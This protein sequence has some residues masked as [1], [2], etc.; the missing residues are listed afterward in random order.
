MSGKRRSNISNIGDYQ[1]KPIRFRFNVG[2]CFLLFL[3]AYM[4]IY[5]IMS[6][7]AKHIVSYEVTKGSLS[8][9]NIYEGVAI[10]Q[11]ESYPCAGTGYLNFFAREG[12]HVAC[13]DL[14]Y[15]VDGSG[16]IGEMISSQ[17]EDALL[18]EEDLAQIQS[19]A[20]QFQK[21]FD[22]T[23]FYSVY[24]FRDQVASNA[25]KLSNYNML[26]QLQVISGGD[27]AN[28]VYAPKSGI[29]V[30]GSDGLEGLRPENVTK[31][32]F[33]EKPQR[34]VPQTGELV[35]EEDTAYKLIDSE[36][37]SVVI[38]VDPQRATQLEEEKYVKVRFLKNQYESWA[39]VTTLFNPDG[40]FVQLD[41]TNSCITFASDRFLSV[42]ILLG[43]QEGLKVPNSAIVNKNLYLIPIEYKMDSKNS[44]DGGFMV[45]SFDE[46]GNPKNVFRD[47]KIYH[48]DDQFF[49]V[50][51]EVFSAG[52]RIIPP[53]G[54]SEEYVISR[55]AEVSGV[56]NMN[57]GYADFTVINILYQNE[58]YSIVKSNTQ[59]GLSEY[60]FI[61]LNADSVKPDQV[62]YE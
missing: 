49:Y 4:I 46:E 24:G 50:D 25:L 7:R 39:K 44:K 56:Y 12:E 21:E 35:S 22:R 15:S 23:Q 48:S 58:E 31:E 40:T 17:Q 38:P 28:F 27:G 60:D 14:I 19:Q 33:E 55:M 37:W 6:L 54:V 41:F 11:E 61:V 20:I 18:S 26:D 51:S 5:V 1:R 43:Q 62:L 29:V 2:F 47:C 30:F 9:S 3:L 8:V 10:R 52:E 16:K 42:E 59:Y 45:E 53:E 36:N 34:R 13:N 32:L 57:K